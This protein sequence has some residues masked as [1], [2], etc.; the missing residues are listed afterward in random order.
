MGIEPLQKFRG[1]SV[2]EI[3]QD[4]IVNETALSCVLISHKDGL[5]IWNDAVTYLQRLD[6]VA[7]CPGP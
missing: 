1:V 3:A 5:Y 4:T 2:T 7:S 6:P